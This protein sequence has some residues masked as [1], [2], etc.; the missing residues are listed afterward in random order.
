MDRRDVLKGIAAFTAVGGVLGPVE[1]VAIEWTA[2][3]ALSKGATMVLGN[4]LLLNPVV[5]VFNG[6][7]W[8]EI[9]DDDAIAAHGP[10]RTIEI[11]VCADGTLTFAGSDA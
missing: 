7:D 3:P 9:S 10:K 6:T 8:V 4:N 1:T 5:L 2:H 11:D